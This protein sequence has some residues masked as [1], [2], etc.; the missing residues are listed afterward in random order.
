M[1]ILA[2]VSIPWAGAVPWADSQ[3][4][5]GFDGS[6]R[7]HVAVP[8]FEASMAQAEQ[9]IADLNATLLR[10]QSSSRASR[11]S[12]AGKGGKKRSS[13]FFNSNDDGTAAAAATRAS[14][15]GAYPQTG[16]GGTVRLAE[17]V[18]FDEASHH[19]VPNRCPG[20][21]PPAY[22]YP[23]LYKM[24][25]A[26]TKMVLPRERNVLGRRYTWVLRLRWGW[27]LDSSYFDVF[28]PFKGPS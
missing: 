22:A 3:V 11:A 27:G 1:E 14:R 19:Q 10:D 9:A 16:S 25:H 7:R 28:W 20:G 24:A 18:W 4:Q 17:V 13:L 21:L 2:H 15:I 12:R 5:M 23:Q 26:F 6:F 8:P